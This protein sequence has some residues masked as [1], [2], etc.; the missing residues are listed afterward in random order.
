MAGLGLLSLS[1]LAVVAHLHPVHA[2]ERPLSEVMVRLPAV[3]PE[4]A[5]QTFELEHGF[6]LEMVAAEPMVGDPVDACFDENGR[7]FV[8]EFHAYPYALEKD[9]IIPA[10][11]GRTTTGII[12]LL[13]DTDQDGVM[14]KSTIFADKFD[15]PLSVVPYN[16]GIFLIDVPDVYYLKDTDGDGVADIREL[17]YTHLGRD[18]IQGVAN[19]MKWGLNNRIWVASGSNGGEISRNGASELKLGRSDWFFNPKTFEVGRASGGIQFGHSMDDWGNRFLCSNSDHMVH[20]AFETR[21]LERN[22]YYSVP[23]VTRSVAKEGG[24]APVF[25]RSPIEPW[26]IVRTARRVKDPKYAGL[27]ESEK[28]PG[29]FFTSAAGITI[30]RGT[31]YPEEYQGNAFVGDV[32]SNLVHRKFVHPVDASFQG[33]RADENTEFITSTDTWFRPVNYVNAPDGTLYILDMYRETIEHPISIPPDIK[34]HLDLESGNDRGRIYRLVS[35][36]MKRI[37]PP[38]LGNVNLDELVQNLGAGNSWNRETAQRLLWERQDPAS[39]PLVVNF[40]RTTQAPLGK[41]HALY[42][43]Q[44]LDALTPELLM[45]AL[46]DSH[47]GIRE[48]AVRLS[49]PMLESDGQLADAVLEILDDEEFRPRFHA[50]LALSWMDATR[51]TQGLRKVASKLESKRDISSAFLLSVGDRGATVVQELLETPEFLQQPYAASLLAEMAT[52]VGTRLERD[53]AGKLLATI[54]NHSG[55]SPVADRLLLALEAGLVQRGSS[56][57][58]LY[59]ALPE[60]SPLRQ[61]VL[62][63]FGQAMQDATDS[64]LVISGRVNG[65]QLLAL[66]PWEI[67]G[68]ALEEVLSPQQPQDVQKA[69]LATM[70]KIGHPEAASL[71]I[72]GWKSFTPSTKAVVVDVLLSR[73]ESTNLFLDALEQGQIKISEID[74]AKFPLMLKHPYAEMRTRAERLLAGEGNSDRKK[75]VQEH[76][77]VLELTG[78]IARGQMWYTQKCSQCHRLNDVGFQVGPDLT[79]VQNKSPEDLLIALLDPNRELQLNFVNYTVASQD[80]RVFTGIIS[81]ETPVSLTLKRAEAKED[82]I[83]RDQVDQIISSGLSLMPEGLE[84]ELNPQQFADIIAFIK[85]LSPPPAQ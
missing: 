79:S 60:D 72:A 25:R 85:S 67:S 41:L 14:D 13:E 19:N 17:V 49:E 5:L 65:I 47:P 36:G 74:R 15:W 56:V 39:I 70:G 71:L 11:K 76:Q 31:A 75:V 82:T 35:P 58:Q 45:E 84:K 73:S 42:T 77:P 63:R 55:K 20:V 48:H 23:G 53:E 21:Y 44:G 59:T 62:Q 61:Q 69:A 50:V 24:A 7:M 33:V 54:M 27:P 4:Q 16:G 80:G 51:G 34:A 30:Y 83:Q 52:L 57:N 1:G 22:P 3:E 38:K 46:N 40:F 8:A 29:G 28:S 10:G 18:N 64:A 37:V 68:A 9:Q 78:D 43:L 66:A 32:G 2:D 12:R 81:S 26:R 6:Q